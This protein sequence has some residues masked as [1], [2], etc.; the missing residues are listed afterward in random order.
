MVAPF[1]KAMDALPVGQISE[2]VQTTFGWH[3]IQVLGHEVR[4]LT[5]AEYQQLRQENFDEWLAR[6]RLRADVQILDYWAERVPTD[7]DIPPGAV[8]SILG[9]PPPGP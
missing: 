2:P 9:Q 6:E 5:D 7:P 3:V 4:P 8:Q 1:E